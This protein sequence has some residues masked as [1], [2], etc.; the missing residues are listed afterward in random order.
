MLEDVREWQEMYSVAFSDALRVKI[1]SG[2]SVKNMAVHLEIA[3]RTNSTSKVLG[4]SQN[5]SAGFW[6]SVFTALRTFS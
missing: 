2:A 4:M 3:V 1:R 6:V 5:E